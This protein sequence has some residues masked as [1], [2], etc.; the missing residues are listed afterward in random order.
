MENKPLK[1]RCEKIYENYNNCLKELVTD[2]NQIL[3]RDECNI[4]MQKYKTI[5][6]KKD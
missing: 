2:P 6:E 4:L 5:C 1:T 3:K